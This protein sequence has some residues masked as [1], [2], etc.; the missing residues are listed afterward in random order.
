MSYA[1]VTE[2]LTFSPNNPKWWSICKS[3]MVLL[4]SGHCSNIVQTGVRSVFTTT[5]M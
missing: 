4:S 5:M 2:N 1:E 3:W